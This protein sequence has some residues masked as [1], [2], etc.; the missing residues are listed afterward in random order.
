MGW[1]MLSQGRI[2]AIFIGAI[3]P[4]HSW[5]QTNLT[6]CYDPYPPYTLGSEESL[7][8]GLKVDLLQAV[9]EHIDGI[10]ANVILMPWKRCQSQAKAGEVDGILPLFRNEE[11]EEYLVFTDV[12]HQEGSAFFY[13]ST[14]FPDGINWNGDFDELSHLRLGMLNGSFIDADMETVFSEA[15]E[16]TRVRDVK[17]LMQLL[18]KSRVDLVATERSVGIYTAQQNGW[19]DK[20]ATIELSISER[21][22][23]FG[24]S[25]ASGAKHYLNA[26]NQAIKELSDAGEIDRIFSRIPK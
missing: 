12:T 11:R 15:R 22:S 1:C 14:K 16:I 25:I 4:L 7:Q 26:F 3:I 9:T 20:I 21:D 17:T 2:L 8:G 23:Q 10:T 24:L 5:A 18:L 13:N 19:Q 6:F